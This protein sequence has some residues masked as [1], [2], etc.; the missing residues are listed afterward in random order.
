MLGIPALDEIRKKAAFQG[1]SLRQ[2]DRVAK[3]GR[4]FQQTTRRMDWDRLAKAAAVLGG[5][6]T[7][8]WP[9]DDE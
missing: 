9:R 3:T 8:K 7:F 4:Y 5:D 1:W 2:L 6:I